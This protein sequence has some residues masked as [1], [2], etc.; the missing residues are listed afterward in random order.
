MA[1]LTLNQLVPPHLLNSSRAA[2]QAVIMS[3]GTHIDPP[4]IREVASG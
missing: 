1:W 4:A 2:G 3:E